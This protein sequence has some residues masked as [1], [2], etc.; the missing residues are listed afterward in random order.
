VRVGF[1]R[2]GKFR[3]KAWYRCAVGLMV[4]IRPSHGRGRGSIP[5]RRKFI[6]FFAQN[7]TQ[8]ILGKNTIIVDSAKT[9]QPWS[10]VRIGNESF[11][12]I[13]SF[14][15]N[16]LRPSFRHPEAN[17]DLALAVNLLVYGHFVE[18]MVTHEHSLL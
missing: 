2:S 14:Y 7:I 8:Y 6:C 3:Q 9:F 17:P 10:I 4:R 13:S 15:W 12:L 5:R 16:S 18:G 1:L 11:G